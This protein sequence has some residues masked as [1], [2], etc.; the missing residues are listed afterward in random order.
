MTDLRQA[1]PDGMDPNEWAARKLV[2]MRTHVIARWLLTG[3]DDLEAAPARAIRLWASRMKMA[4][5]DGVTDPDG[6]EVWMACQHAIDRTF[7]RQTV[8]VAVKAERPEDIGLV[9]A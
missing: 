8:P 5:L 2:V 1:L 6:L 7:G 9:S 4:A 3:C